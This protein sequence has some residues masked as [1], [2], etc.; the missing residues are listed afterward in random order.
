[1]EV[2]DRWKPSPMAFKTD[3][4]QV[5]SWKKVLHRS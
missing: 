4:L 5:Q 1:M 3:S 2:D